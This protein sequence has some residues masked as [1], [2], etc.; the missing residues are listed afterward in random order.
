MSAYC[1]YISSTYYDLKGEREFLILRLRQAQY[2]V[3]SMET[4]PPASSGNI[5]SKC[6]DDVRSA[7][8]YIC[9][10]GDRYGSLAIDE[11]GNEL[12]Y[13]YTEYEYDAAVETKRKML[14]FFKKITTAT[15]GDERLTAFIKKIKKTTPSLHG[16]YEDY[17]QLPALVL[18]AIIA[19][20]EQFIERKI[21][22]DEIYYCDRNP[23]MAKLFSLYQQQK[24][25]EP[26]LLFFLTG[27]T[28][29]SHESFV[30]RYKYEFPLKRASQEPW[31]LFCELDP[32]L[33]AQD[34][35]AMAEG[36]QH[37]LNYQ[38]MSRTGIEL[39]SVDAQSLLA[40]MQERNVTNCM[41]NFILRASSLRNRRQ[42]DLC[43]KALESF[44]AEF[45][46]TAEK[47]PVTGEII[48]FF[49]LRYE[50]I[51]SRSK[52]QTR[53]EEWPFLSEKKLSLTNVRNNDLDYWLENRKI[54]ENSFL[55]K[56]LV[57]SYFDHLNQGE[58]PTAARGEMGYYMSKAQLEME[59]II[60]L[61]NKRTKTS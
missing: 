22:P 13:S 48:F 24:P 53:M 4:Y 59:K 18:A 39:P 34:I 46:R 9:I 42:T 1:I 14:I 17:Q 38:L 45:S 36:L 58:T 28:E 51:D 8:I 41:I 50:E 31:E 55:R 7:H 19:E 40:A 60:D 52:P 44:F 25:K 15:P 61:Y 10:I 33:T 2:N 16:T 37:Q 57:L 35:Q 56:S 3:V 20:T 43:K 49:Q 26:Y 21:S 6:I 47:K 32:F 11:N 54:E 29:N 12:P 30:R 23:Q 5:R 27:H